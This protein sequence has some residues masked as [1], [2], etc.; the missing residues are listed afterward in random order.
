LRGA[1]KQQSGDPTGDGGDNQK[2]EKFAV[3]AEQGNGARL[4]G[5]SIAAFAH[6]Q[7][8]LDHLEPIAPEIEQHRHQRSRVQGNVIGQAGV[9]PFEYPGN[10]PQMRCAGNRQKLRQALHDGEYDGLVE[11]HGTPNFR[12]WIL[13]FGLGT[14]APRFIGPSDHRKSTADEPMARWFD[15]TSMITGNINGR[16]PVSSLKCRRRAVRIFSLIMPQSATSSRL[17]FSMVRM[18]TLRALS[19]RSGASLRGTNPRETTSGGVSSRPVCSL[20]ARMGITMPSSEMWRRSLRMISSTSSSV[21]PSMQMR[22]TVTRPARR[23]PCSSNSSTSPV[24]SRN[25][26]CETAASSLAS[27]RCRQSCRY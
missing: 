5:S 4:G 15:Q 24:S 18:I 1:L 23:A 21:P 22:P 13:G 7:S 17:D 25:V 16:L 12:F 27:S 3:F 20:M 9:L 10:Q 2:P 19:T 8:H 26:S 11:G 14:S 6:A